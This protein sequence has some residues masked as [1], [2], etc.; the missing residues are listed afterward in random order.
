MT[1]NLSLWSPK[2]KGG[3]DIF[4]KNYANTLYGLLNLLLKQKSMELTGQNIVNDSPFL[5]A[6]IK[7]SVICSE[8][9][10]DVKPSLWE[11][12]T[13]VVVYNVGTLG[14]LSF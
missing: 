8:Y 11:K 7:N 14:H 12:F 10:Y 3:L 1:E 5:E 6:F 13:A 2:Q 9:K 4:V